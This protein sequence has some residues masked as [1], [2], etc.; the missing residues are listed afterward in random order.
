MRK[1]ALEGWPSTEIIHMS[2][3]LVIGY[4]PV[5]AATVAQLHARGRQVAVA[6]RK[7]PA[8]LPASVEFI[9]CDVTDRA[10]LAAATQGAAQIVLAVG[11]PYSGAL[12]REMWPRIMTNVVE[13]AAASGARVVFVDNLYMY[14]PQTEPLVETMPL[15]DHAAKPAA[16]A[17]A[18]RIW[19]AA[20]GRVR[21]AALRGPD[22]YGPGVAQ[23]ILGATSLGALAQGKPAMWIHDADTPHDFAFVPDYARAAVSLLDAPDDAFGQAW[24]VPCAPTR[25]PR[26]LLE[27]AASALGQRLRVRNMPFWAM[28]ALGPFVPEMPEFAEMR[29]QWDRPYR[30]D[31][32]KF[33]ARFWSDPTPFEIGVPLAARSFVGQMAA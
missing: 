15:T 22:F 8:G 21:F 5:G 25:R 9:A 30:V 7:R 16:R 23:A 26:E 32:S 29:F 4:G 10:S 33:K 31:A 12:W 3:V 11:L 19:Q 17:A 14:G 6:Q 27:M 2:K 20:S 1:S 18:T 13:T 24:H 28:R